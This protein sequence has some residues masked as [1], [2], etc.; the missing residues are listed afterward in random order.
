MIKLIH[1][2]LCISAI[3][4]PLLVKVA[5]LLC[6]KEYADLANINYKFESPFL[7]EEIRGPKEYLRDILG[8]SYVPEED[9]EF[10]PENI[11]NARLVIITEP[12][13]KKSLRCNILKQL[14]GNDSVMARHL[15]G[16][17]LVLFQNSNY[18]PN[19]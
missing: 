10:V 2:G 14:T 8:Y 13:G 12:N 11:K 6:P 16:E 3:M 19:K 5:K 1:F 17:S 7:L 15:Y 18:N 4:E 9:Y